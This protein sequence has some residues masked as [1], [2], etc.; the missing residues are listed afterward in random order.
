MRTEKVK[1]VGRVELLS[2]GYRTPRWSYYDAEMEYVKRYHT[3]FAILAGLSPCARD[4]ME[5]LVNNMN[6]ENIVTTNEY[7]RTDFLDALKKATITQSG[8]FISY[9][10]SNIK[11]A[12][13]TLV[14]RSC[15]IKKG[16][17]IYMVNPE[18][19]FNPKG[20]QRERL[21]TIKMVLEFKSGTRD[22][23]L[24]T[25]YQV[26]EPMTVYNT[27]KDEKK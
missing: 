27:N 26:E 2:D 8:E 17:G 24:Q 10:D 11:K 14:N 21:D 7:T 20:S 22:V 6:D 23:N 16:R 1:Y 18:I 12:V 3:V 13:Q 4:F 19:Y 5:Y 25:L 15:L 9:S